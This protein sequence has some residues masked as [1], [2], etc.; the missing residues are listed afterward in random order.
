MDDFLNILWRQLQ[1][2]LARALFFDDKIVFVKTSHKKIKDDSLIASSKDKQIIFF[3]NDVVKNQ[4]ALN[5][6][7]K[8]LNTS[9]IDSAG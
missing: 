7:F 2:E 5:L 6:I 9:L 8:S 3:E 1:A 4:L